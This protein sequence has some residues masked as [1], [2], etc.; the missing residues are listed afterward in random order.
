M[1]HMVVRLIGIVIACV[2]A[3]SGH[4]E[5]MPPKEDPICT[6]SHGGQ[7]RGRSATWQNQ[8]VDVFT[9]NGNITGIAIC[10]YCSTRCDH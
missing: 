10:H 1:G 2:I 8:P 5:E 6:L 4:A 9:G 7:L 3:R